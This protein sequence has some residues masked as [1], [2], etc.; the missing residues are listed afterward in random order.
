MHHLQQVALP[1]SLHRRLSR[2]TCRPPRSF[3]GRV[4]LDALS[5]TVK[6]KAQQELRLIRIRYLGIYGIGRIQVS[7]LSPFGLV[8][9]IFLRL[10]DEKKAQ[11]GLYQH[12]NKCLSEKLSDRHLFA[13]RW[14]KPVALFFWQAPYRKNKTAPDHDNHNQHHNDGDGAHWWSPL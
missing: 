5:A 2:A 1:G 6:Q 9:S 14:V 10:F 12:P 4:H 13:L 7:G 8:A 11:S 3:S